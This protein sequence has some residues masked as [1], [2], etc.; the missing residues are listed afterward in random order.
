MVD[1][2]MLVTEAIRIFY[3]FNYGEA[4]KKADDLVK[5]IED[6]IANDLPVGFCVVISEDDTHA[7]VAFHIFDPA[8]EHFW[9][10]VSVSIARGDAI[11]ILRSDQ[12]CG[13]IGPSTFLS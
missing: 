7:E 10:L 2:T 6:A 3:A 13:L 12:F 5:S 9:Q 11:G 4:K 1:K 8:A